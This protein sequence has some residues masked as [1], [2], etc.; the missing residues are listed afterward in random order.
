VFFK[1]SEH[2]LDFFR[3][4]EISD[5]DVGAYHGIPFVY[6][7]MFVTGVNIQY[8]YTKVNSTRFYLNQMMLGC[9]LILESLFE[10]VLC[11]VAMIRNPKQSPR[12]ATRSTP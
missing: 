2:P 9:T 7:V 1:H 11:T 3:L 12:E 6:I 5:A 8:I 4:R 10:M